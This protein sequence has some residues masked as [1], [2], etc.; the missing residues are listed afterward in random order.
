M[1][2]CARG[3]PG[4]PAWLA[5]AAVLLLAGVAH[6]GF[7]SSVAVYVDHTFGFAHGMTGTARN[8]SGTV[9]YIECVTN[10]QAEYGA[11]QCFATDANG[12]S[13]ACW[14]VESTAVGQQLGELPLIADG[15]F[16]SFMWDAEGRCTSISITVSSDN[17]PKR[18]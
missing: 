3:R 6:A 10:A 12:A 5:A 13:A 16:I 9:E 11:I 8:R 15:A 2:N 7:K 14:A 17:E 4:R 18:P 1:N